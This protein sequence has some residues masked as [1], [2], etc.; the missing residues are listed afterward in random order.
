MNVFP[1]TKRPVYFHNR[2]SPFRVAMAN[3][4]IH[5]SQVPTKERFIIDNKTSLGRDSKSRYSKRSKDL[6][7]QC[8]EDLDNLKKQ[9]EELK[10]ES[11]DDPKGNENAKEMLDR[12]CEEMEQL[13]KQ[14][15]SLK[16]NEKTGKN[17]SKSKDLLDQCCEQQDEIKKQIEVLK[18]NQ[19][20]VSNVP[21]SHD[22]ETGSKKDPCDDS[23]WK[24]KKGGKKEDIKTISKNEPCKKDNGPSDCR[25]IME[26]KEKAE[27]CVLY[28]GKQNEKLKKAMEEMKKEMGAKSHDKSAEK[29]EELEKETKKVEERKKRVM[30]E[31]EALKNELSK[32]CDS[33]GGNK[34]KSD[35]KKDPCANSK[36]KSG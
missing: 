36:K 9:I 10:Q 12:C 23:V 2:C 28:L 33:K 6:L 30:K 22:N 4:F 13:K 18:K 29:C 25:K 32:M 8:C 7:G 19:V 16:E 20:V 1:V 17:G 26:K 3:R 14:L 15:E 21:K 35:G 5:L 34:S 24:E 31:N 27:Q 11:K